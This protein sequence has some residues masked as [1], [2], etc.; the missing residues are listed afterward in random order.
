MSLIKCPECGKEISD[1][2]TVCIHCGYPI[3]E[4]TDKINIE[5]NTKKIFVYMCMS[6]ECSNPFKEFDKYQGATCLCPDCGEPM[7]YYETEIIDNNT[8][9]VVKRIDEK[10]NEVTYDHQETHQSQPKSNTLHCPKCGSTAITTGSRGINWFWGT[11]GSGKT[12]NR[13]G[14]CGYT[15][16]PNGK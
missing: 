16:K 13:C 8:E 12:V 1:K 3:K 15:W 11:I 7:D 2:A 10:G 4:E 14:K 9:L 5:Q 6:S